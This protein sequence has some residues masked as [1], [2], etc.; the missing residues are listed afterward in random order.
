MENN[1]PDNDCFKDAVCIDA[2]RIYDS[3]C[4]KDCIE[5]LRVY[6]PDPVQQ[7]IDCAVSVKAKC[8]EVITAYVDVQPVP[9]NQGY[10]TV[11]ITFFFD[12]MVEVYATPSCV[13]KTEC[14]W[15]VYNKKIVLFGSEGSVKIF[16]SEYDC[17]A[18]NPVNIPKRNVP[19]VT[20]QVA[21]PILLSAR[22]VN[23]KKQCCCDPCCQIPSVISQRYGSC[24]GCQPCKVVLA[25]IGLFSIAQIQ[26]NVQMLIPVYDFCLPQKECNCDDDNNACE[27]FDKIKFPTGQFF[28]PDAG[29]CAEDIQFDCGCGKHPRNE[30]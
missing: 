10:Y 22:L 2:G 29:C 1:R 8:A 18:E 6:F 7:D 13:C 28:P 16:T 27:V 12:V 15:A 14:G 30:E 25:S 24:C 11:D 5:D 4:A 23:A 9:F 26:R 19:T 21:D 20:V 3:C 17:S